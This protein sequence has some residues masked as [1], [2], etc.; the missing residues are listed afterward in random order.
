MLPQCVHCKRRASN[1]HPTSHLCFCGRSIGNYTAKLRALR[2]SRKMGR[3]DDAEMDYTLA[4]C[5]LWDADSG[6]LVA[7]KDELAAAVHKTI[8]AAR[9]L[10]EAIEEID[11]CTPQLKE[12]KDTVVSDIASLEQRVSQYSSPSS[13]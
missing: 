7:N 12:R 2:E 13:S 1:T 8:M 11:D 9:L 10:I 5:D 6:E 3:V 4:S